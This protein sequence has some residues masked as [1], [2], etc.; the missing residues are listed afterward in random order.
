MIKFPIGSQYNVKN[1]Y[2]MAPKLSLSLSTSY[3]VQLELLFMDIEKAAQSTY[4]GC[5]VCP[6]NKATCDVNPHSLL[7]SQLKG[8]WQ[9]F[10]AERGGHCAM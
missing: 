1:T 9:C 6:S 8:R 4:F 10:Y 7:L 2:R 3:Q 5:F